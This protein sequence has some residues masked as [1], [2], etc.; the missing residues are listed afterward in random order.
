MKKLIALVILYWVFLILCPSTKAQW[1]GAQI[2]QLTDDDLPNRQCCEGLYIDDNDKLHLFYLQGVRDTATGFVYDY[3]VLYI[4][5]EKGGAWSQPEQI[6]T[7]TYVFGQGRKAGLWMDTRTG[8]IHILYSTY[9]GDIYDDTLYYTNSTIPEWEFVKIDSLPGEQWRSRYNTF[10]MDFDSLGNVHLVWHLDFDSSGLSWY[11]VIYANNSTGEWVK[12]VISPPICVGYGRSGRPFLCIQK[13]GTVHNIYGSASGLCYYIRN[14]SLNSEDWKRD[15][16]PRPQIPF[17][18]YGSLELL[19]EASDR[20]HLFTWGCNN[21]ECDTSYS[22]Y[23]Y[24][25]AEDSIWSEP[26][27]V[28][29]YPP[30]SGQIRE[31]F[32]D[33][34]DHI[35]LSIAAPAGSKVFYTHNKVGSWLE[36]QPVLSDSYSGERVA[37]F[38]FVIDSEGRGHGVF[39]DYKYYGYLPE[40]DS[41]EVYYFAST[42]SVQDTLEDHK[43]FN[44]QLSQNYPNPFNANTVIGYSLN[45][46]RP[47]PVS[48]KLYNILGKEV[49]R[50]VT[51]TQG[52]GHYQI[53]WDGKDNSGKEVASGIYFY[54]LT[55]RQ[56]HRPEQS[57]GKAADYKETKKLVLVK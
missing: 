42:T 10:D 30:D 38:K 16:I 6:Q 37:T 57:G 54:Q 25:Q 48:L 51:G 36:P 19:A 9:A 22:F 8:I 12:Q 7:S 34:E 32:L 27:E 47:V 35:H 39:I 49:R 56:V 46:A 2:Q 15:T 17:Y 11:R 29:V 31:Y 53:V 44:L 23:Y 13:D 21:W 26:E 33:Q 28:Q 14:D 43:I 5:K 24:K 40:D 3:R 4:T 1:E 20:I 52:R 18:S 50:L 41:T 55:V 45:I